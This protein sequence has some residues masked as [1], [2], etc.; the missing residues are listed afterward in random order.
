M[1]DF[2]SP[3]VVYWHWIAFGLLLITLEIFAPLFVTL[4]LGVAAILVGMMMLVVSLELSAQ[5]FMWLVLSITLII[6][7]HRYLSPKL[8]NQASAGLSRETVVGQV[9]MVTDFNTIDS[10]G[11]LRFS[12]PIIDNDEWPFV[13]NEK[14][15]LGDKVQVIDISGSH[16]LV[17]L[18]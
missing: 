7:W 10:R 6:L 11:T 12:A 15:R 5:L 16:L 1:L 8:L 9:G 3:F 17:K 4:W 13:A 2:I 18:Y 14:L